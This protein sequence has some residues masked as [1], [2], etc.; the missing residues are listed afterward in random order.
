[1]KYGALYEN[2]EVCIDSAASKQFVQSCT[3]TPSVNKARNSKSLAS[4]GE[5][6]STLGGKMSS[7][8]LC[9]W[10][11]MMQGMGDMLHFVQNKG[12]GVVQ[13]LPQS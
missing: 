12:I 10:V 5:F 3:E 2:Q 8:V 13:K 11:L 1:M 9:L 4:T 7:Y 6:P